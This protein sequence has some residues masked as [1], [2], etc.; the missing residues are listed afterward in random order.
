MNT[1]ETGNCKKPSP[2]E[3]LDFLNNRKVLH[4]GNKFGSAKLISA[5]ALEDTNPCYESM[6][7]KSISGIVTTIFELFMMAYK[8][9][10]SSELPMDKVKVISSA[11]LL[12]FVYVMI[13]VYSGMV[14]PYAVSVSADGL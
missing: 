10:A 9:P 1:C 14:S 2:V 8:F 7:S 3:G 4:A 11:I 5:A 6:E 13:M 12:S